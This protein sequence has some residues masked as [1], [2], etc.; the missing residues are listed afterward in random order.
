[1][2]TYV[3]LAV[4]LALL[5]AASAQEV[6]V[7]H[8]KGND[9]TGTLAPPDRNPNPYIIKVGVCIS[10]SGRDPTMPH[11][12]SKVISCDGKTATVKSYLNDT[13]K[14]TSSCMIEVMPVRDHVLNLN[15]CYAAGDDAPGSTKYTSTCNTPGATVKSASG[16]PVTIGFLAFSLFLSSVVAALIL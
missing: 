12:G 14:L 16:S 10:E 5:F 8:Y 7:T 11:E 13:S 9:C 2:K 4:G 1:M 3:L 15:L 6:T